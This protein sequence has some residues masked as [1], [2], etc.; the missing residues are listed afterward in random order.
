MYREEEKE[1]RRRNRSDVD[2]AIHVLSY[3][4]HWRSQTSFLMHGC[5]CVSS[6][7]NQGT[8]DDATVH[9]A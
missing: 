7:L 2:L 4:L 8:G 6:G 1:K 5:V 3:V 9:V